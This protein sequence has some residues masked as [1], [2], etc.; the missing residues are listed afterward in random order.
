MFASTG[1]GIIANPSLP[2]NNVAEL[3]ALA[4]R[5]PGKLSIG[6]SP[7]GSGSHLS[8]EL[9]KARTGIDVTYVPYK[10]AAALNNDLIGG[11][12]LAVFSVLPASLGAIRAGTLKV[13]AMTGTARMPLLP[14]VP[15]VAETIPG[16]EAVI[17]YGLLVP[18]G[19]PQPII[20]RLNKELQALASSPE[21]QERINN[22][23]G[24]AMTS[25]PA[26]Y[27]AEIVREDALW[28]PLDPRAQY[29]GGVGFNNK[30]REEFKGGRMVRTGQ[31]T[32]HVWRRLMIAAM[33]RRRPRRRCSTR[34]IA[35]RWCATNCRSPDAKMREA[36]EVTIAGGAARYSHVVR[37]RDEA[38]EAWRSRAPA[39]S[40]ARTSICRDR[41]RAE[42]A[43]TRRNTAAPS[44]GATPSSKARRPGPMAARPITRACAGAIKRPLK[45][46]LPRKQEAGRRVSGA[47]S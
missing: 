7:P 25:T 14:D 36:I 3:I 16:F 22:E 34:S 12:I 23:A 13:L 15:T 17:R 44:C 37:L 40:A 27:A 31:A 26:E 10:G 19:T 45:P 4:K 2:A 24:S 39:R 43:N 21:V 28:G 11:H 18:A 33:T 38:A 1:I 46:F 6:T 32:G 30:F 42:P 5:E 35:A 47:E 41:G 29:Q 9:F 8:A 20:A